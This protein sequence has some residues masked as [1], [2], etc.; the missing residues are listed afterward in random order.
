MAK[1][2]GGKTGK[3]KGVLIRPKDVEVDPDFFLKRTRQEMSDAQKAKFTQN[4]ELKRLLLATRSA[5]LQHFR[6][7]QEPEIYDTLMILR[8]KL[9]KGQI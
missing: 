2:A 1:G 4:E 9:A 5:K 3:Y 6:K 7:G 8:D